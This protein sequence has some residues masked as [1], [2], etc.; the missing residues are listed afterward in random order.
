VAAIVVVP[1]LTLFLSSEM[2]FRQIFSETHKMPVTVLNVK[3]LDKLPYDRFV[4][5][6]AIE[7]SRSA[8]VET[9]SGGINL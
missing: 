8:S 9:A 4:T 2:N 5:S 1:L 6:T 3:A 7:G